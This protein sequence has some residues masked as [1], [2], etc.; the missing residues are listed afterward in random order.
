MSAQLTAARSNHDALRLYSPWPIGH[1][2]TEENS[3]RVGV[4]EWGTGGK[5]TSGEEEIMGEGGVE[6]N[7]EH[8][9]EGAVVGGK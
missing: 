6:V 5:E 7:E 9:W 4:G 2:W 1:C 8:R 3:Q